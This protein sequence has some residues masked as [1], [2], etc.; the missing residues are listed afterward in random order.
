MIENAEITEQKKAYFNYKDAISGEYIEDY[1]KQSR[2][3]GL[4]ANIKCI[5]AE[6]DPAHRKGTDNKPSMGYIKGSGKYHCLTCNKNANLFDIVKYDYNLETDTDTF[7]KLNEIYPA[8]ELYKNDDSIKNITPVQIAD[9]VEINTNFNFTDVVDKAS[10]DV[11]ANNM[12]ISY[13]GN[14]AHQY[15]E[16][17]GFTKETIKKFKL[18]CTNDFND[19]LNKYPAL[20][21]KSKK[22]NLYKWIIPFL[23]EQGNCYNFIAEI[24]NREKIDEYN[25]KYKKITSSGGLTTILFNEYYLKND[26][27]S[28][29]FI[30]EGVYDAISIEQEGYKAIALNGVGATRLF[31]LLKH[32][33]PN[34][35]LIL[36]LDN[37]DAGKTHTKNILNELKMLDM[38]NIKYIDSMEIIQNYSN[39]KDYK[40]ANDMLINNKSEFKAFIKEN[41]RI[42]NKNEDTERIEN[43]NTY[44]FLEYFRTIEQQEPTQIIPT[45]FKIL[46][47]N[48]KGGL[49]SALYILGAVSSLG[50]TAFILQMADQ[51]AF[52]GIPVLYFSL[53]MDKKELMARSIAR[54]TYK[55]V[56]NKTDSKGIAV[57][58]N[59]YDILD[60]IKYQNYSKDKKS[61][62]KYAIDMY[63]R[64]AKNMY[65]VSGRY[66][67][68]SKSKRM[69]I[70]DIEKTIKDF[71]KYKEQTPVIF[72]D[73][74]Q[75]IASTELHLTDK[76]NMDNI[77]DI[78]KQ[79]SVE[80]NTPVIAI[81]SYNRDN[82]YEPANMSAF[83]ESGSI[84]YGADYVLA[85]QYYGI[86]A[87]YNDKTLAEKDKKRKIYELIDD[88]INRSKEGQQIPVQLKV[89]KA[90]NSSKFSML[91]NLNYVYG[92]FREKEKQ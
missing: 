7:K 47:N 68:G 26:K 58:S 65:I 35:N 85:L 11:V 84:E 67:Q 74:M 87:I 91:F 72:I 59:T 20:K 3:K 6:S 80:Y 44:N 21:T 2:G 50:K 30:T 19:M 57:A 13:L 76:Q 64:T 62:I 24:C 8:I 42:I 77:V 69:D 23:D 25:Q 89:L 17:R 63:E 60:N 33:K 29:I 45:D 92:L 36:M 83:K 18:G 40:D 12:Q 14:V 32:Y 55:C 66:T 31:M 88:I 75:I 49:R 81:S 70:K 90:R 37:D 1:I 61:V 28:T 52:N 34:T 22:S 48:L 16:K 39:I 82:Y 15:Y 53:E 27:P 51:I 9:N 79:I 10:S 54:N 86:D 5:Y 43:A 73:Y 56:G 41:C 4:R 78:L 38:Q 46:D 71:I